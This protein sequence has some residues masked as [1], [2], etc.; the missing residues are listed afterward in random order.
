MNTQSI[1]NAA[2]GITSSA[3]ASAQSCPQP[4]APPV[5]AVASLRAHWVEYVIEA[6]LLGGFMIAACVF[7]ALLEYPG[8]PVR[9]QIDS[10]MLR[11]L[12][13][14]VA[15]GGTAIL[16]IYSPFGKRSG[17]HFNPAVTATFYRLNKVR[18]WDAIFYIAFQFVGGLVGTIL[19]ASF[20][21]KAITDPHVRY[22]VT[23]GNFGPVA[24]FAAE[25][26]ITF[27]LMT[28]VL[29][30]SANEKLTRRT[31][32]AA[33]LLVAL[34][35]T[36][37]APYSGMSMNP[38]RTL[39]SAI[40]ANFYQFIWIYFTAPPLGMLAA[41]QAHLWRKGH[42]AGCAKLHHANSKRCIFCGANGGYE[43]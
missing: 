10:A 36:I 26:V 9:Q 28:T 37:E 22:V 6:G 2:A 8:S 35:I 39:A 14:G 40:P 30:F 13:M 3:I 5:G 1:P 7:G 34:F 15:M 38:A 4:A 18:T 17:A 12:L 21:G 43:L 42:H 23:A 32:L 31:G 41:A 24:A 27:V 20:L 16:L 25:I 19:A 29:A 11:R 33:G